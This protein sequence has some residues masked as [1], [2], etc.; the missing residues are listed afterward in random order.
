MMIS[1]VCHRLFLAFILKLFL[2]PTCTLFVG[3]SADFERPHHTIQHIAFGSCHKRKKAH[4]YFNDMGKNS[5][6]WEVIRKVDQPDAWLWTGDAVY[7]SRSDVL[8]VIEQQKRENGQ[9]GG[10]YHKSHWSSLFPIVSKWHDKYG[11]APVSVLRMEYNELLTNSSLGYKE[12]LSSLPM[13]VFGTWDDHDYGGNDMGKEI[14]N[15]V[16]R[17]KAFYDFLQL[18][19]P[20][21]ASSKKH[22]EE[23]LRLD[24]DKNNR[25]RRMGVYNSVEWGT[26]PKKVKAVMLDTRYHRDEHCIPS[27]GHRMPLG[28]GVACGTRW[29]TAGLNLFLYSWLW[30]PKRSSH[31]EYTSTGVSS[32]WNN[33]EYD[34]C[35]RSEILG[36]EQWG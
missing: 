33:N 14:T 11:P 21:M 26:S 6:I 36:D 13:G 30:K 34:R 28:N 15:R 10:D 17:Q 8:R 25:Q 27:V 22:A 31:D 1:S 7:T 9:K 18:D 29:L 32:D 2:S 35:S 3:A 4:S 5:T 19:E 23:D 16:E 24:E 20:M 12:F